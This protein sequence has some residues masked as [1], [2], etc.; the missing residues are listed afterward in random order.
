MKIEPI[1]KAPNSFISCFGALNV[2]QNLSIIPNA[3]VYQGFTFTSITTSSVSPSEV[4]LA[5]Y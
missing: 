2:R 5:S 3:V 4:K 1:Q